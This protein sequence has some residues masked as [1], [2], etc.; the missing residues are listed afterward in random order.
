RPKDDKRDGGGNEPLASALNERHWLVEWFAPM[1]C[2][3]DLPSLVS[4]QSECKATASTSRTPFPSLR[5]TRRKLRPLTTD[6]ELGR[7]AEAGSGSQDGREEP[8]LQ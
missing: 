4:T 5:A 6:R 3:H 8:G 2:R 1:R 7:L